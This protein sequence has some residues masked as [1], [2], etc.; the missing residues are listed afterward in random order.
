MPT[1][2]DCCLGS[3]RGCYGMLALLVELLPLPG[4]AQAPAARQVASIIRITTIPVVRCY[5]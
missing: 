4:P 1:L 3:P 5:R 2:L